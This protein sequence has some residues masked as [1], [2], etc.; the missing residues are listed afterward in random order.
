M[1]PPYGLRHRC[2]LTSVSKV[3]DAAPISLFWPP[4]G[5]NELSE[6]RVKLP[7]ILIGKSTMAF[8]KG[9]SWRVLKSWWRPKAVSQTSLTRVELRLWSRLSTILAFTVRPSTRC[10]PSL[11]SGLSE[12]ISKYSVR[13]EGHSKTRDKES[14]SCDAKFYKIDGEI[15]EAGNAC[16]FSSC[17]RM[18]LNDCS[19]N[20]G[21]NA[22]ELSI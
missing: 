21:D 7:F 11:S 1:A 22:R 3:C 13:W 4:T 15:L 12:M 17:V 5:F 18:R 6:V 14:L 2:N 19:R 10:S 9:Q 8:F 20:A 16:E